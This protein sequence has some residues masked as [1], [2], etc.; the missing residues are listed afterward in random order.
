MKRL[1]LVSAMALI[2]LGSL[3]ESVNSL[4]R[5]FIDDQAGEVS[6]STGDHPW[7]GDNVTGGS[8][9]VS[10]P[11]RAMFVPTTGIGSVDLVLRVYFYKYMTRLSTRKTSRV[12]E[13]T[14]PPVT[15]EVTN[16]TSNSS[17]TTL[18]ANQ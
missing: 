10:S 14:Q 7:G 8:G 1:L 15:T 3:G 9:T 5:P 16:S 2:L 17:G 11:S 13:P 12:A 6:G 18:T 4:N